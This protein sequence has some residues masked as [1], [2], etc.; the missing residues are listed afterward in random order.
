MV[1]SIQRTSFSV[2]C[3]FT[4]SILFGWGLTGC[5]DR[6]SETPLYTA[7]QFVRTQSIMGGVFSFD[8][9]RV[10]FG[11]NI[12]GQ[13][14]LY[15]IPVGGGEPIQLTE[16][17]RSP[18][19]ALSY[20][21]TD[22]RILCMLD[23]DGS[24]YFHLFL[25]E[26]D[27]AMKDLTPFAQINA[28]FYTWASDRLGFYFGSDRRAAGTLDVY[29]MDVAT[30]TSRLIYP[31]DYGYQFA[32]VDPSGRYIALYRPLTLATTEM[33]L[34]DRETGETSLIS[35]PDDNS[36]CRPYHFGTDSSALYFLTD[37]D[38]EFVYLARY[39]LATGET[40][41]VTREPGDFTGSF[42]SP[43]GRYQATTVNRDAATELRFVDNE[44][45]RQVTLSNLPSGVISKVVFSWDEQY[46][47]I[48]IDSP[49]AP[50]DLYICELASGDCRQLVSSLNPAIQP[51]HLATAET[52]R[53]VSSDDLEIPA[54]LYRPPGAEPGDQR[55]ALIWVHGGPSGQARQQY[56]ALGQF[57][58]NRGYV[59]LAVNYRGSSGYGKSF[60]AADD[61]R[62]GEADLA[63][64]VAAKHYLAGHDFV[65][66]ERIAI[67]GSG[68]GGYL[69][70]AA[71]AFEPEVFAVGIDMFGV[72]NWLRTLS[73]SMVLT[74][75]ARNALFAEMGHPQDEMEYLIEISPLF[76]ADKIVRPLLIVQGARDPQFVVMSDNMPQPPELIRTENH[77]IA[78]ILRENGV[79][80][81]LLILP[82]EAYGFSQLSSQV[83]TFE[84]I[85]TFL[86]QQMGPEQAAGRTPPVSADEAATT[87]D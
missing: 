39:D 41:V 31:N 43:S 54:I 73:A 23:P 68:Y 62:H 84:T 72:V 6:D 25:R 77:Q 19:Y 30:F 16:A 59:F 57:L 38:D 22:D 67:I 2:H 55:P 48:Y 86:E 45:D 79:P 11:N 8:S 81:E 20:L 35:Q 7:E 47:R 46:A 74:E 50:A 63:D 87:T 12:S 32:S 4:V 3:L 80:V 10:L 29:Y 65:D 44:Q 64:C 15:S 42:T 56:S 1:R 18:V 69:A 33:Y 40:A 66:P 78:D 75:K 58:A 52:V 49:A 37:R 60:L 5:G 70:L 76:Q 61:H 26:E 51:K 85:H 28:I 53:F 17:T 21:P 83:E 13:F 34:F 9:Q 82:N 27:G 14:N 24:G 71:L 36:Y